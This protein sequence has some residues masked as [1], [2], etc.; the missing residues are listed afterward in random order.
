VTDSTVA[1]GSLSE[2]P[3]VIP[4]AGAA[5]AGSDAS[6]E[7]VAGRLGAAREAFADLDIVADINGS[8]DY[9]RH[10]AGVLLGRATQRAL[11]EALVHA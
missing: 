7:A 2:V 11:T 8:A 3:T 4:E 1:I 10:L 9:K 6:P 5:F